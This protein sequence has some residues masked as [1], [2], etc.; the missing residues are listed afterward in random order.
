VNLSGSKSNYVDSFSVIWENGRTMKTRHR[1]ALEEAIQKWIENNCEDLITQ[2]TFAY[3]FY[4]DL[5]KD[6]AW[7]AELVFDATVKAQ[8][9]Y[10]DENK[11]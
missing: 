8:K 10:V 7:A 1:L 2:S 11:N 9:K 6:M 3:W 5:T 4:D